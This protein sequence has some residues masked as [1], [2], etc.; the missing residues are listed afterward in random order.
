MNLVY[1]IDGV[2]CFSGNIGNIVDNFTDVVNTSVGGCVKLGNIEDRTVRDT[3]AN[4]TFVAGRAVLWVQTVYRARKDLGAGGLA[5]SA[6]ATEEIGM[7]DTVVHYLVFQRFRNVSLTDDV[8][9]YGRPPF[10]I[11]SEMCHRYPS[12]ALDFS[13]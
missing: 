5:R 13:I 9:E 10:T 4:L 11:K 3:A 6:C 1:D 12:I 8:L 7:T 2:T